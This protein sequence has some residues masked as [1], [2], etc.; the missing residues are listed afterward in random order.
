MPTSPCTCHLLRRLARRV[1]Q[2]Y[3]R[4]VAP[5]GLTITQFSLLQH[6]RHQPGVSA[7]ALA[8]QVGMERTTLLRNLRPVIRDG[9]ARYR[10]TEVGRSA[11]LELT[12][13]GLERIRR[14]RPLWAQAQATLE[15]QL[16]KDGPA[17][18]ALLG[19]AIAALEPEAST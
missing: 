4:A 8:Q 14:A 12:P 6:L 19:N 13:R 3:D 17:L 15:R 18:H 10:S 7:S 2:D 5:A 11:E 9:L 1:T 16:G